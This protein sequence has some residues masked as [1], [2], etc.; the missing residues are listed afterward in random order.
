MQINLTA[1]RFAKKRKAEN[2]M[3]KQNL[4]MTEAS[5]E[6]LVCRL[7]AKYIFTLYGTVANRSVF[8][9]SS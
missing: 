6:A 7:A 8:N 1:I 9:A 5:V 2:N 4:S 3:K